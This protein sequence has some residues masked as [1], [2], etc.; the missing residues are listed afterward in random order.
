MIHQGML[1]NLKPLKI[2][3]NFL[4]L[5]RSKKKNRQGL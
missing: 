5:E 1:L 2:W 4:L 3:N